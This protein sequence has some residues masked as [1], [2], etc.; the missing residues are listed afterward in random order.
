[1]N[2]YSDSDNADNPDYE[3]LGFEDLDALMIELE[4][5]NPAAECHGMLT[6]QLCGGARLD[7]V[8]LVDTVRAYMEISRELDNAQRLELLSIYQ[9]TLAQLEDPD[10]IFY[11]LL[12]GEYTPLA[13]RIILLKQWCQGFLSGF[14]LVDRQLETQGFGEELDEILHD[15]VAISQMDE[16]DAGEELDDDDERDFVEVVEYVRLLVMNVFLLSLEPSPAQ[17]SRNAAMAGFDEEPNSINSP[18]NLFSN[19]LH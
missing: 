7:P 11:P 5:L 12:P 17:S 3:E 16:P 13:E 18:A 14:A 10:Q 8:S 1:M 2:R 19:K 4:A 9:M 6:G 15:L